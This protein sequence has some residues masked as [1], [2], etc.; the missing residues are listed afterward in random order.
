MNVGVVVAEK[1]VCCAPDV[2]LS[3]RIFARAWDLVAYEMIMQHWHRTEQNR[4]SRSQRI[5]D[6]DAIIPNS[7]YAYCCA[8]VSQACLGVDG[9]GRRCRRTHALRNDMLYYLLVGWVLCYRAKL[10]PGFCIWKFNDTVWFIDILCSINVKQIL[11][12]KSLKCRSILF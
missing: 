4:C 12:E 5:W 8:A 3:A 2:Q 1:C 10:L 6:I 11:Q 9:D 7:M